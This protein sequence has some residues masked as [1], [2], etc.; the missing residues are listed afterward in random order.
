VSIA[1]KTAP[2]FAKRPR[3]AAGVDAQHGRVLH[4]NGDGPELGLQWP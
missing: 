4:L 1:P 3:L 2:T